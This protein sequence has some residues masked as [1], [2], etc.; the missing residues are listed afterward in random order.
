MPT[1]RLKLLLATLIILGGFLFIAVGEAKADTRINGLLYTDETW[2]LPGSPYII[3]YSQSA[4]GLVCGVTLIIEPGVVVK[5]E[6]NAQFG[7]CG[8]IIA[9]G[10]AQEPIIFTAISD[11]TAGGDTNEDGNDT[12]PTRGSWYRLDL[13]SSESRLDFVETRYGNRCVSASG[14]QSITNSKISHCAYGISTGVNYSGVIENNQISENDIGLDILASNNASYQG[15]Q[16]FANTSYGIHMVANP[17]YLITLKN[18]DIHDNPYGVVLDSYPDALF[19]QNNIHNNLYYGVLNERPSTPFYAP[20]NWWGH[21]SGPTHSSNP[22]GQGDRISDG[23]S[24]YP[25]LGER[26]GEDKHD[27]VI[28]THG[29][30]GSQLKNGEYVIDPVFH[31]YD[32]LIDTF[33]AN[34]YQEGKNLFVFA[35]NWRQSNEISA[36]QLKIKIREVLNICECSKVDLVAHSMGGLVARSYIQSPGYENNIDQMIFLGTPHLGAPNAYLGWEGGEVAPSI[37]DFAVK[38]VLNR[39]AR[40]QGFDNIF[41]YVRN[42]PISSVRELLPIY[43]YLKED[44]AGVVRIYPENYPTNEFL[45]DLNSSL[46]RLL[47]S[48]V[49]ITNIV[50]DLGPS[51]TSRYLRVVDST[52]LP[53]WEHGYP[54][55]FYEK[56]GD[57]GLEK[58]EGDGTVPFGSASIIIE[59]LNVLNGI[60]HSALPTKA[61]GLIFEKLTGRILSDDEIIDRFRFPNIML[62][63]KMLSPAD[64]LI[65]APDGKRIGKDFQTGEEYDEIEGAFYSGYLTDDEFIT[66]PDPLNGEYQIITQGTDN[67]G[68]YTV[69]VGYIT[70]DTLIEE[71]F[72]AQTLPGLTAEINLSVDNSNPDPLELAPEDTSPPEITINS[73]QSQDYLRSQSL[74]INVSIQ[75]TETGVYSSEMKFDDTMVENN[76]L[77]DLFFEKLGNHKLKVSASDFVGNSSSKE[78]IFRIIATIDST[79]SDVQRAYALGWITNSDVK[80]SLIAKLQ[81]AKQ[82]GKLDKTLAKSFLSLLDAQRNKSINEQ[83]YQLLKEDVNWL[84]NN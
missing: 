3:E 75:D 23:V 48:G 18:N 39:E 25:W 28:I 69:S 16:I 57:R 53:L 12:V 61:S 71:D 2:T 7:G 32:D 77:I 27:P 49:T 13:S 63:I 79:I 11:D 45:E 78:Q 55:G 81:V 70:E 74:P 60:E 26:V 52:N 5:F 34:G 42:K 33:K 68:E 47:H 1:S 43:N 51:S 72:V 14:S 4:V 82:K 22:N 30:L 35:Y 64:M 80:D 58:G 44:S 66:I 20:H 50:S 21:S 84:L 10:T 46:S 38:Y 62:I 31:V 24:F 8:K 29:I 36:V 40:K 19:E 56:L 54:E 67:G 76:E 65:I 9:S 59:D 15:N 6:D 73:P 37:F 41:D 17:G 83:A